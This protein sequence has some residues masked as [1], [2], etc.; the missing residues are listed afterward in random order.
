MRISRDPK[1]ISP[2]SE[3]FLDGGLRRPNR[4]FRLASTLFPLFL[5]F[6]SLLHPFPFHTSSAR[7]C[8]FL[9][10]LAGITCRNYEQVSFFIAR[11]SS[12]Y[13][14]LYACVYVHLYKYGS[15]YRGG[16]REREKQEENGKRGAR[17]KRRREERER[18]EVPLSKVSHPSFS[19]A[20]SALDRTKL[21]AVL[22]MKRSLCRVATASRSLQACLAANPFFRTTFRYDCSKE[23]QNIPAKLAVI[24]GETHRC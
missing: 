14:Y 8:S 7:A 20:L 9:Q 23:C 12:I 11:S 4:L 17:K 24:Y 13:V 2:R 1:T 18:E 3:F 10:P 21:S 19:L 22:Q 15:K 16:G 6:Y 5:T